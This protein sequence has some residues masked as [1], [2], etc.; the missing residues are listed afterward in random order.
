MR[1]T[2]RAA[3]VVGSLVCLLLAK[4]VSAQSDPAAVKPAGVEPTLSFGGLVQVQLE[5]GDRGDSRWA[6]G[7][8][9]FLLRRTRLNGTGRF[10]EDFDFKVE[11]DLAGTLQ[12]TSG[13]RAQLTDGYITWN[14]YSAANVRAG[15]LKTPF[16]FEQLYP[17]PRLITLERSLVNDRL[18][19]GRQLGAQVAGELLDKRLSY[20]VG[21]FNGNGVNNNFNDNEKF[22]LAGRLSVAAWKGEVAGKPTS[23]ALGADAFRSEDAGLALPDLGLDS[24][25]ATGD[26]DNLFTGRRRGIG[27]DT[28]LHAGPFDLWLEYLDTRFEPVDRLPSPRFKASGWYGQ[29]SWIFARRFQAV[30][31]LESFDPNDRA[32]GDLVETQ[33]LGLNYLIKGNDLK[34]MLDYLRTD[35]GGA[36]PLPRQGKALARLQV[37]F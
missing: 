24:T 3:A 35:L 17:D 6:N 13:L 20:A 37:I 23:W 28:Q 31:K 10:L 36:S 9:R 14:R 8:D 11:L 25:P 12:S 26:R 30:A 32:R 5:A 4:T 34:L 18:T 29:A 19:L 33:T 21:E 27:V 22:V 1:A 16:G 7:N 2:R 15:Q